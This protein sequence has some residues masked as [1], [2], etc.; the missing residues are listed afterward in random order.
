MQSQMPAYV[1]IR[2]LASQ[3]E[4][5][6]TQVYSLVRQGVLPKPLK[7]SAGC[8]RWSWSSVQAALAS[9]EEGRQSDEEEVDHD[10]IMKQINDAYKT[11]ARYRAS[12]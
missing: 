6:E 11:T 12:A 3:L 7:L 4:I 8:V 9:L 5:G 1:N 10:P 2:T